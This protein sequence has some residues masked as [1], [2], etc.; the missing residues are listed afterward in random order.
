MLP[1]KSGLFKFE[2]KQFKLRYV[3][4]K[5][6]KI[7]FVAKDVAHALQYDNIKRAIAIYVDTKYKSIYN[8]NS[9]D[10][11][12][13]IMINK[14][15]V[16][17][18]IMKSKSPKAIQLQAWFLE[19]VIPQVL[20]T[21]TTTDVEH[22]KDH[23][24]EQ[25]KKV[26]ERKDRTI[27]QILKRM[28]HMYTRFHQDML[29]E[30]ARTVAFPKKHNKMPVI[31][32]LQDNNVVEAI[33]GQRKYVE[34]QKAI[35]KF[36]KEYIILETT[37]INPALD[38]TNAVEKLKLLSKRHRVKKFPRSVHFKHKEDA[39]RFTNM[40][41]TMFLKGNNVIDQIKYL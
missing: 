5:D 6:D 28:T 7:L 34:K 26:C 25:M 3:I 38:W 29:K 11:S 17:Q 27:N 20:S 18:L 32:I 14:S 41:K 4:D 33:T 39:V 23:L 35:R 16:I 22:K 21:K 37:R 15:G 19:Q 40:I 31:C 1:I 9:S 24:V 36:K 12:Q 30:R 8:V 2:D 10:E 13:T